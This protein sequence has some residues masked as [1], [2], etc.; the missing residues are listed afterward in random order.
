MHIAHV[1]AS[2]ERKRK[3]EQKGVIYAH[4]EKT[5]QRIVDSFTLAGSDKNSQLK[6]LLIEAL[7]YE[8]RLQA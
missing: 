1:Y 6:D 2:K 7:G 3:N 5:V 8:T 4:P